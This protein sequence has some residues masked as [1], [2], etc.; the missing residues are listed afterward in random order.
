MFRSFL[1]L[2]FVCFTAPALSSSF[3]IRDYGDSRC[4]MGPFKQEAL[5]LDLTAKISGD[6]FGTYRLNYTKYEK[7]LF[8][9]RRALRQAAGHCLKDPGGKHHVRLS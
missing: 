5:K 2:I 9:A 8:D 7:N 3:E 6:T 4:D 1:V